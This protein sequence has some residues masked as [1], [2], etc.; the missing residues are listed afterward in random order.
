MNQARP[1]HTHMAKPWLLKDGP[2][3]MRNGKED[4]S[5]C[6]GLGPASSPP[7]QPQRSFCTLVRWPEMQGALCHPSSLATPYPQ[8][9]APLEASSLASKQGLPDPHFQE[10]SRAPADL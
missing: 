3:G 4:L 2:W 6:P 5:R 8:A 9:E 7:Q 10:R 1:P